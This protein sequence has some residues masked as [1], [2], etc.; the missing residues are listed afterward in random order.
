MYFCFSSANGNLNP[1]WFNCF[2]PNI[3]HSLELLSCLS[4]SFLGCLN[5]FSYSFSFFTYMYIYFFYYTSSSLQPVSHCVNHFSRMHSIFL[6]FHGE[7]IPVFVVDST[8]LW[9][10]LQYF[11]FCPHFSQKWSTSNVIQRY[12]KPLLSLQN[13]D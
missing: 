7:N 9:T 12:R 5:F 3:K 4:D 1:S 8:D 6:S 10:E 11:L 2:C 13:I